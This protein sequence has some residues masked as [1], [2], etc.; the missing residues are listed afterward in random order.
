[1]H[2]KRVQNVSLALTAFIAGIV[3]VAALYIIYSVWG[4]LEPQQ[5]ASIAVT[6]LGA[7][8][9]L[10]LAVVT[11]WT[12][13]HNTRRMEERERESEKPLARNEA[14]HLIQP[15]IEALRHNISVLNDDVSINWFDF[16]PSYGFSIPTDGIAS[17]GDPSVI[18]STK[19]P[20]ALVRLEEERPTLYRE[21][22][23]H[24]E[25]LN[26]LAKLA[27]NIG[28][29]ID[30]PLQ[31]FVEK[32]DLGTVFSS[33]SDFLILKSAVL[34]EADSYAKTHEHYEAW[35]NNRDEFLDILY[36]EAGD[37][38]DDLEQLE[39]DYQSRCEQLLEKLVQ[40]KVKLQEEYG[41]VIEEEIGGSDY[42]TK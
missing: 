28:E 24:D 15:A 10:F 37:E 11:F 2:W 17:A 36:S 8:G 26:Q 38:L 22:Q 7:V 35:N 40:R 14:E 1:M 4:T 30:Y 29:K 18:I 23:K 16:D 32:H 41:F 27:D 42:S 33:D 12:V 31:E 5:H 25:L 3:I 9:T 20:H 13:L 6:G 19:D 34:K 39:K 21:M